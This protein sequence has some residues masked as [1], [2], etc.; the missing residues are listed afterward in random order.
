MNQPSGLFPRRHPGARPVLAIALLAVLLWFTLLAGCGG[1]VGEGGTGGQTVTGYS[2]GTITGFGSVIVNGVRY[3][4]SAAAVQDLDGNS[5]TSADLRLGMTVE[6]DS[7]DVTGAVGSQTATASRIR[8]SSELLGPVSSVDLSTL[9]LT[10]LGQTV[11][12]TASTVLDD[13]LS[14]GLA[15]LVVGQV[16]EVH[17]AYDSASGVYKATRLEPRSSVSSYRLRGVVQ[18]LDTTARSLRLGAADFSYGSA[19]AVPAGLAVGSFVR[20]QL[21]TA[22]ASST[23]WTV[24]S[25]GNAESSVVDGRKATLKGLITSFTSLAD[26][27][28][29]GQRVN[30]SAATVSGG[31]A[32][33]LALGL[34]VEVEGTVQAG[35]LRAAEVEIDGGD[36]DDPREYELKGAITSLDTVNKRFTLREVVVSYAASTVVFKDG[37]AADLALNRRVEV[38]GVLASDGHTLVATE[39]EFD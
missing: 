20:L 3:D 8:Y 6:V 4:D 23:R 9:R 35:V 21:Q 27:S 25:F 1:G 11:Q 26:F 28:V 33:S 30:A 7:G 38:K 32:T 10:L 34:R 18:Q 37:T 17:G 24:L 2:Q 29:N 16:L 5:K 15:G 14:T 31:S 19:S 13:R 12:L 36:D 22:A 39:I